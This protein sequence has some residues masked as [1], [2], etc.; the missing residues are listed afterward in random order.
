MAGAER[1]GPVAAD[2]A[3]DTA[4]LTLDALHAYGE[5]LGTRLPSPAMVFLQG[6]LGAGKT[7]LVQAICRGRGVTEPVTSPTF[8]LVH[9]YAAAHGRVVHVD[10]Y[11]LESP[12]DVATLGLDD[13]LADPGAILLVEWPDRAAGTLGSP[14]LELTLAH[15]PGRDDVRA[16]RERWAT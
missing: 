14:T 2:A 16:V 5:Q 1:A 8:A 9:E 7:T 4:L 11:R 15:E 10:L 6:D 3:P 12:R 13:V